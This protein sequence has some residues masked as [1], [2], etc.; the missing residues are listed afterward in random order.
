MLI[1]RLVRE[2]DHPRDPVDKDSSGLPSH[3]VGLR[4]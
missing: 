3:G 4:A 2:M 1:K